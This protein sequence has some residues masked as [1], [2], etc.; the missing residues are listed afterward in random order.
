MDVDADRM[1]VTHASHVNRCVFNQSLN[2]LLIRVCQ[3]CPVALKA[4]RI[5]SSRRMVVADFRVAAVLRCCPPADHGD[6]LC[7][8]ACARER[9]GLAQP[10]S[11]FE[12]ELPQTRQ[13]RDQVS[14]P[15][16]LSLSLARNEAARQEMYCDEADPA[17]PLAKA[18]IRQIAQRRRSALLLISRQLRIQNEVTWRSS[19]HPVRAQKPFAAKVTTLENALG[20][21]VGVQDRSLYTVKAVC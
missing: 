19:N 2:A 10:A 17:I 4:E 6:A 5:S 21:R 13:S 16:K 11:R 14:W 9:I 15:S 1:R 12:A 7:R 18:E 20:P 8:R 3:P